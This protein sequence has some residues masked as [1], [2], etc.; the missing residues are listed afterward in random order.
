M[1]EVEGAV[2][3]LGLSGD[4]STFVDELTGMRTF[5]VF[6]CCVLCGGEVDCAVG[7][8]KVNQVCRLSGQSVRI[9]PV[10]RERI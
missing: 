3:L 4:G 8:P 7:Q 5:I 10:Y 9:K 2:R 1:T 6:G